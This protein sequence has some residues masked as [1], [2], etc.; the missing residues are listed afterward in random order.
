MDKREELAKLM[1][2]I[3]NKFVVAYSN[4]LDS[5]VS[6]SQYL[7]LE[8]LAK[9]GSQKSSDMAE[10]LNVS[11]PAITNLAKKLVRK[12]YIERIVPE[13]DRRVTILQI[14]SLG[15]QIQDLFQDRYNKLTHALWDQFTDTEMDQLQEYYLKMLS[16]LD[17]FQDH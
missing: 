5:D 2:L 15:S 4:I 6:A 7:M 11:L 1:S 12:G 14:T 17:E 10:R 13:T 3:M 8:I 16:N 9:E